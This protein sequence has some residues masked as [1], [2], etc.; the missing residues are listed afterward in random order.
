MKENSNIDALV[1]LLD[2]PDT[3]IFEQ[4]RN[5]LMEIGLQ[6][7]PLLEKVSFEDNLGELFKERRHH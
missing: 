1:H 7:I 5:K 3:V 4:I 2:D 6:C